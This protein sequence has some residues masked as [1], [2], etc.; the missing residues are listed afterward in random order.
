MLRD[1][2]E[3]TA[4]DIATAFPKISRPA[5]SRH[6]RVLR[7][8]GLVSARQEGRKWI[9]RLE[10]RALANLYRGWLES[11]ASVWEASLQ[12]LKARVE[13]DQSERHTRRQRK[14]PSRNPHPRE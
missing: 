4:G 3:L 14:R 8:S 5:V 9:Y 2:G 7:E 12:R 11:F 1:R 10:P 6:L 13:A